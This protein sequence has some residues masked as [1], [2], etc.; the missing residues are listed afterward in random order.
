MGYGSDGT[1]MSRP[2]DP[3][4][5]FTIRACS[6]REA[7]AILERKGLVLAPDNWNP[8]YEV[9]GNVV[10]EEDPEG[11]LP[12]ATAGMVLKT[13][14]DNR[15][16]F[17]VRDPW[18]LRVIIKERA[19]IEERNLLKVVSNKGEE[20]VRLEDVPGYQAEVLTMVDSQGGLLPSP[21]EHL[22]AKPCIGWVVQRDEVREALKDSK[23]YLRGTKE[24]KAERKV[25][26]QEME[27]QKEEMRQER[28]AS[29]RERREAEK[30]GHVKEKEQ[31]SRAAESS[32]HIPYTAW[33]LRVRE[34]VAAKQRKKARK[35][36]GTVPFPTLDSSA[37]V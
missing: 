36:E 25:R 31:A 15:A 35:T 22:E 29:R 21:M 5:P 14:K 4:D 3:R 32:T 7:Q 30:A 34:K 26:L 23:V 17:Y 20:Q 2:P 9:T 18:R 24:T 27:K 1:A 11:R 33:R 12:S 6:L 16:T 28:V 13:L 19:T 37:K 8:T 10:T